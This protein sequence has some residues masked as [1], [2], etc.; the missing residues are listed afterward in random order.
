MAVCVRGEAQVGTVRT[1]KLGD[2]GPDVALLQRDV[3]RW[4][5][6]WGAP[7]NALVSRDG[8]LGPG[9]ARVVDAVAQILGLSVASGAETVVTPRDAAVIRHLGIV[10][11]AR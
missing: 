6:L 11:D 4:L 5:C 7:F 1:I 3:S 9:T 10:A 2:T 8:V